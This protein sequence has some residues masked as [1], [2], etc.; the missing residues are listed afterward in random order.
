MGSQTNVEGV[1]TY[2]HIIIY[3]KNAYE[4]ARMIST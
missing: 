4:N 2:K 1:G 3:W